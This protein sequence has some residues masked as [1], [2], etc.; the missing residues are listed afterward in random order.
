MSSSFPRAAAS[1]SRWVFVRVV[2]K[3]TRCGNPRDKAGWIVAVGSIR[4]CQFRVLLPACCPTR[5]SAAIS[6]APRRNETVRQSSRQVGSTPAPGVAGGLSWFRPFR[7]V[8]FSGDNIP[9]ASPRALTWRAFSPG[10]TNANGSERGQLMGLAYFS[11]IQQ[12][13]DI[14]RHV[15]P[16]PFGEPF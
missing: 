7:A 9:G 13:N 15:R 4:V 10:E 2:G 3:V 14:T 16:Q 11:A 12:Q 8:E 6:A 1:R 5:Q